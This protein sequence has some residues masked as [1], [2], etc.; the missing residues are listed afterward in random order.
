MRGVSRPPR[1]DRFD[2]PPCILEL[3]MSSILNIQFFGSASLCPVAVT[4]IFIR[5]GSQNFDRCHSLCF[6]S[7]ATGS[8]Q[9]RPHFAY[10]TRRSTSLLVR[11]MVWVSS[12]K[13]K[14]PSMMH[15]IRIYTVIFSNHSVI[16]SQASPLV[17]S[18]IQKTHFTL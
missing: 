7:S 17:K 3:K 18:F 2:I 13:A 15:T 9:Q 12:P 5:L 10:P 1:Y 16:L 6:A 11:R 8:A 14:Y 4:E